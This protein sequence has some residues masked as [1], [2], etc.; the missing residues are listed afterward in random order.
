MSGPSMDPKDTF[1]KVFP[2]TN[3]WAYFNALLTIP[4]N[5]SDCPPWS[6]SICFQFCK[7]RSM[8]KA[9]KG[10]QDRSITHLCWSKADFQSSTRRS[11]VVWQPKPFIKAAKK[12]LKCCRKILLVGRVVCST[13]IYFGYC[14]EYAISAVVLL[15]Y[16][17]F[18]LKIGDN[19]CILKATR[20]KLS[21]EIVIFDR[22]GPRKIFQGSGGGGFE[23][24][25][26]NFNRQK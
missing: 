4:V 17:V 14:R 13:F 3:I 8:G 25:T 5:D 24:L 11:N 16:R 12:G 18:F 7:Q 15:I 26:I 23:P 21:I 6:L 2:D 1:N 10:L 20:I 9:F 22:R 19:L